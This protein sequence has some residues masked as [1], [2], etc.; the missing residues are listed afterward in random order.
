M[1]AR[2]AMP[3]RI[4]HQ[5][6]LIDHRGH[7]L[8]QGNDLASVE[9]RMAKIIAA[10]KENGKGEGP[11][12][13]VTTMQVVKGDCQW[14]I[15]GG[16]GANEYIDYNGVNK[17]I[18]DPDLI[19]PGDIIFVNKTTRL[20]TDI[21]GNDNIDIFA[22]QQQGRAEA[23]ESPQ[24]LQRD[25]GI[26]LASGDGAQGVKDGVFTLLFERLP[27][28]GDTEKGASTSRQTLVE[29]YLLTFEPW[30]RPQKLLELRT[31]YD[32]KKIFGGKDFPDD[33]TAQTYEG[34]EAAFDGAAKALHLPV[35]GPADTG[36]TGD[37]GAGNQPVSGPT[38]AQG[39]P[40]TD[41]TVVDIFA[42]AKKSGGNMD[43]PTLRNRISD[44]VKVR[45]GSPQEVNARVKQ[46]LE[47]DFGPYDK[48]VE[49]YM[50]Q[51]LGQEITTRFGEMAKGDDYRDAGPFLKA[52]LQSF[53]DKGLQQRALDAV[54]DA[55]FPAYSY[56]RTYK[57]IK[58]IAEELGL[59]HDIFSVT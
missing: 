22:D 10:W 55:E 51:Y 11:P 38:N 9:K 25:N 37:T 50:A 30:E 57:T 18:D 40:V 43:D 48:Q 7:R 14:T 49:Q 32:P 19:V 53:K 36:N 39:Q 58:A 13:G 54:L 59:K 16:A 15:F 47:L 21:N 31:A 24:V 20:A 56:S 45:V 41:Q 8:A 1:G 3:I 28:T 27:E 4:D 42:A 17:H 44:F 34:Y 23:G 5:G 26:F 2:N 46:L 33:S 52:Y 35:T 29:G 12:K 6:F